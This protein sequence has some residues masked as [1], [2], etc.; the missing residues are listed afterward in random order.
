MSKHREEKRQY[1][2]GLHKSVKNMIA[3]VAGVNKEKQ[4][5]LRGGGGSVAKCAIDILKGIQEREK[6]KHHGEGAKHEASDTTVDYRFR[7]P[8]KE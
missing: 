2:K 8:I 5:V 1:K 7:L 6:I 4:H 3:E